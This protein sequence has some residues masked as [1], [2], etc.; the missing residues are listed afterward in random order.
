MD[1]DPF[2]SSPS[3]MCFHMFPHMCVNSVGKN[4]FS[5]THA[6]LLDGPTHMCLPEVVTTSNN[7]L[8]IT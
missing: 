6:L 7:Q 4:R 1:L 3:H 5:T 2:M 8:L